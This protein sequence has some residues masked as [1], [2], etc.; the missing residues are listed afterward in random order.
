MSQLVKGVVCMGE[1]I[2]SIKKAENARIAV[3]TCS[4]GPQEAE[5]KGTVLIESAEDLKE[6]SKT[7]EKEV[8]D[9]IR[10][11]KDSGIKCIITG[12]AID[13][14]PAHFLE[15]YGIM[16]LKISSKFEL[17]RMCRAVKARPLV[18]VGPVSAEDMG[19]CGN[20]STQE[21][22][23][24]RVTIFNHEDKDETGVAT[25]VLRAATNNTLNDVERAIDDGVNVVKAMCK[26]APAKFVAGAGA[27]E[28]EVSRR[29]GDYGR[30]ATGLE[31][32][33]IQKFAEAFEVIPR[34]LAEN[35]GHNGLDL[36]SSL[37]AAHEKGAVNAGINVEDGEVML[38]NKILDLSVAKK[39]AI[40]LA[41][42]T[43]CTILRVDQIIIAKQAGGPKVP[44]KSGWDD[45]DA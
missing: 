6:F 10:G 26:N 36:F 34:T 16:A 44:N 2:N 11:L 33:S 17:R 27:S 42:D 13:D 5:T 9:L 45:T 28:V 24:T 37:L 30:K 22:G 18:N 14:M 21:V 1:S 7:E 3:F 40:S 8:D 19:F 31:Q 4:I 32:Y 12:G 20:I 43:V 39:Q 35:A 23:A 29:L 15:K 41:R 38:D 25:I